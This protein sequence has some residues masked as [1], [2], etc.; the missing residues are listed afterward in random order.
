MICKT[1]IKIMQL[2]IKVEGEGYVDS[3][4]LRVCKQEIGSSERGDVS[5]S[6][7]FLYLNDKLFSRNLSSRMDL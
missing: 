4:W 7:F 3:C 1:L 5:F 6:P 2:L